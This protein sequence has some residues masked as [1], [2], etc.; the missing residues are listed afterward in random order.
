MK[1]GFTVNRLAPETVG[2][3]KIIKFGVPLLCRIR[4]EKKFSDPDLSET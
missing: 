1:L 4:D 2:S 3:K